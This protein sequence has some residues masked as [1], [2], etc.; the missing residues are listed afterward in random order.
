MRLLIFSIFICLAYAKIREISV[1]KSENNIETDFIDRKGYRPN[2]RDLDKRPLPEWYD[3]AKIGI[4]LH[5]GVY[6][7]PSF[8]SEWFWMNWKSST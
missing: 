4:F 3:R 7:V 2:W 1:I 6:A 8:G 5:W